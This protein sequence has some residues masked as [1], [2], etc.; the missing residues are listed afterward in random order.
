MKTHRNPFA[1]AR[2]WLASFVML[3]LVCF[4]LSGCGAYA[5]T[6]TSATGTATSTGPSQVVLA[7]ENP[8]N[9]GKAVQAGVQFGATA[10]L[11]NNSTYKGEVLAAAD[12]IL[13]F[14]ASNPS[15]VTGA[16]IASVLANTGISTK[17]QSEIA[18]YATSGLSLFETNFNVTFPALKPNYAIYLDAIANGLFA[19]LG[20]VSLEVTLP[21]IPWPPANA[22]A[23]TPTAAPTTYIGRDGT[24][25]ALDDTLVVLVARPVKKA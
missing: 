22:A 1:G 6:S 12:G 25:W 2:A 9:I 7:L 13:A 23:P 10:F 4:L 18:S 16:D 14:G 21:V 19:A 15:G 11:A 5:P 17:T 20:D 24:K 3:F 8:N